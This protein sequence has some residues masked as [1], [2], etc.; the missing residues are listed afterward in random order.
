MKV[1]RPANTRTRATPPI[2]TGKM[3]KKKENIKL[4]DLEPSKD[5]KGG[6]GTYTDLT[7]AGILKRQRV[8]ALLFRQDGD[9]Y[10]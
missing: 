2:W 8:E 3:G 6:R 5:A 10:D 1:H 7:S 4:S 9:L